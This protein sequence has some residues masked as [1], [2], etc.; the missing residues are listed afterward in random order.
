MKKNIFNMKEGP[1]DALYNRA[2]KLANE[3]LIKSGVGLCWD[4]LPDTNSLWEY[5]YDVSDEQTL[6]D[7]V[8][9]A[10]SDRLYD[11]DYGN[12]NEI[13]TFVRSINVLSLK[14]LK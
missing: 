13:E 8:S 9:C 7:Q 11:S 1:S 2:C 12:I 14:D 5:L 10:V 3:I 4:D 6:F